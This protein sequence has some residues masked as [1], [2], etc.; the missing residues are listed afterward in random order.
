M[1]FRSNRRFSARPPRFLS[2]G[3]QLVLR[4]VSQRFFLSSANRYMLVGRFRRSPRSVPLL[5]VSLYGT[6]MVLVERFLSVDY[7]F[8]RPLGADRRFFIAPS[9]PPF[10]GFLE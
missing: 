3:K 7:D 2:A 10:S 8:F 4:S 5:Y 6:K 1:P 9:P